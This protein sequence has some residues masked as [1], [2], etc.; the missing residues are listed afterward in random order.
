MFNSRK[1][2]RMAGLAGQLRLPGRE[3]AGKVNPFGSLWPQ[4]QIP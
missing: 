4:L 2:G 1:V 3:S